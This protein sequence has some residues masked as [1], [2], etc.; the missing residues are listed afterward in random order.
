MPTAESMNKRS[1]PAGNSSKANT[2]G[3]AQFIS[4]HPTE[5]DKVILRELPWGPL[6]ALEKAE[7]FLM[8][9]CRITIS[10]V[11]KNDGFSAI[12]RGPGEDWS[13]APAIGVVHNDLGKC[14]TTLL[15]ALETRFT[16]F[17]R[18]TMGASQLQFD[19]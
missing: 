5:A 9:G 4:Y 1:L 18:D 6:E 14:L 12:I 16:S 15:Y 10:Y 11:P 13:K 3:A 2:T 17:P 8:D 7:G 19:W